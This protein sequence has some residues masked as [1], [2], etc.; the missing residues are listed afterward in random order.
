MR[1]E[2]NRLSFRVHCIV[3]HVR[4]SGHLGVEILCLSDRSRSQL[5]ELIDELSRTRTEPLASL[6]PPSR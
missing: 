6:C 1:F 3:R 5:R 2:V 4:A